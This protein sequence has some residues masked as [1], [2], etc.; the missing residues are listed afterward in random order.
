MVAYPEAVIILTMRPEDAW[1]KSMMSTLVHSQSMRPP[2]SSPMSALATKYHTYCWG[3]DF[4][5]HGRDHFKG[6]NATVRNAA[7]GRKFLEYDVN[8]GWGPLCE[9]LDAPVPKR[10]FPRVDDWLEYKKQVKAS[11]SE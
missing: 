7:K 8:Q 6:H 2:G 1:Y 5:S 11:N 4:P 10:P 3:N 9:F